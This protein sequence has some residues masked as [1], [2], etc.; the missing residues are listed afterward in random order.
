MGGNE[1]IMRIIHIHV[2]HSPP[3]RSD[4]TTH[5]IIPTL[6]TRND[7]T[8]IVPHQ[9]RRARYHPLGEGHEQTQPA[10][11]LV[12]GTVIGQMSKH[13]LEKSLQNLQTEEST[14]SGRGV[15]SYPISRT[16]LPTHT[17]SPVSYTPFTQPLHQDTDVPHH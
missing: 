16:D 8:K 11:I 6:Q 10:L 12:K 13:E 9:V 5:A 15:G 17:A 14:E 7:L 3:P 2:K 4:L 1:D